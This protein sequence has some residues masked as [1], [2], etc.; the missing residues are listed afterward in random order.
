MWGW[1]WHEWKGSSKKAH[2]LIGGGI[3]TLILSTIIIGYGTYLK[4][5]YALHKSRAVY[6]ASSETSPKMDTSFAF[7]FSASAF[8][9]R[10]P[11]APK[12][13]VL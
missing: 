7:V 13:M 11:I 9:S 4:R 6:L 12:R 1:I 3:A 8:F 10:S 2:L 5:D